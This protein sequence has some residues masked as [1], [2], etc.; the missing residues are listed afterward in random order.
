MAFLAFEVG[1]ALLGAFR[2]DLGVG[3]GIGEGN[4]HNLS[5]IPTSCADPL[6]QLLDLE[7]ILKLVVHF[8]DFL[9][10]NFHQVEQL[11]DV[12]VGVFL[13]LAL[14]ELGRPLLLQVAH[15]DALCLPA[16]V[17]LAEQNPQ[18]VEQGQL[19]FE[20]ISVFL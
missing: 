15:F 19:R 9:H 8:A 6:V 10:L 20:L 7:Y 2:E 17:D 3:Q 5:R 4:L 14:D 1:Q 13:V 18:L 11:H 12:L 16:P